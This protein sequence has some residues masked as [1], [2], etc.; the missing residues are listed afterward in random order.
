MRDDADLNILA[1]LTE[2]WGDSLWLAP[3]DD[4]APDFAAWVELGGARQL[5]ATETLL[6]NDPYLA[7]LG[8]GPD[9]G[10]QNGGNG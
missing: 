8:N 2:H 10:L 9:V 4:P 5:V 6:Q 7:A 1:G 3:L